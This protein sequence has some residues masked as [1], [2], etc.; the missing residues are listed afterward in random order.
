MLIGINFFDQRSQ[1]QKLLWQWSM[2]TSPSTPHKVLI[3][4]C[5]ELMEATGFTHIGR[6]TKLPIWALEKMVS[7]MIRHDDI[8]PLLKADMEELRLRDFSFCFQSASLIPL[9]YSIQR[10]SFVFW[11]AIKG[12]LSKK[13]TLLSHL[14]SLSAIEWNP[15][16][17]VKSFLKLSNIVWKIAWASMICFLQDNVKLY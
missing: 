3:K 7:H 10:H 14:L 6:A 12:G 15:I 8:L 2:E 4:E 5:K 16:S 13:I 9:P 17:S 11:M 1:T